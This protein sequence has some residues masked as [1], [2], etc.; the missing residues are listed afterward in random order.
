[1]T[2]ITLNDLVSL[3]N[4]TTAVNTI[5]AN[6]AVI[7]TAFDNTLSRDGTNPNTMLSNLDM[8]SHGILN[9]PTPSS[10]TSP[11]RV[12]DVIDGIS[13][14]VAPTGD[15]GHVVPF[16]DIANVWTGT[17]NF[18]AMSPSFGIGLPPGSLGI[19]FSFNSMI[20]RDV[21][22][23]TL[24]MSSQSN[25]VRAS[26]DSL[27]INNGLGL[28]SGGSLGVGLTFAASTSNFGIFYGSGAPTLAAFRGSLYL[29][30][31]GP[32]NVTRLYVNVD[33]NTTWTGV[34]T[35]A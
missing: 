4:E 14:T 2:K 5:N 31:D 27:N 35:V 30:S 1:M 15:Q 28:P 21:S 6:N 17:Q 29:R 23:G 18:N 34:N 16:L 19:N 32:S 12:Q 10:N 9:L 13:T 7:E 26:A 8:N 25:I 33:G 3:Q 20:W 24:T 11:I 22:D